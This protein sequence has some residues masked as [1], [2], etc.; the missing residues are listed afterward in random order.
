MSARPVLV[1][2][3]EPDAQEMIASLLTFIDI[4]CD[5]ASD[6]NEALSLL[7]E[8]NYHIAVIDIGLPNMDGLALIHAIRETNTNLRCVAISAFHSSRLKQDTLTAGFDVY[9]PKPIVQEDFLKMI[10]QWL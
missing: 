8:N 2:E 1:V 6:G 10:Q 4:D 9:L 3:D 5:R 7:E